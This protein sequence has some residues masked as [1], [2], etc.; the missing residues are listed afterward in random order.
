MSS[1]QV[2]I[3]RRTERVRS[4]GWCLSIAALAAAILAARG[5]QAEPSACVALRACEPGGSECD[6]ECPIIPH[7]GTARRDALVVLDTEARSAAAGG[8]Y[9]LAAARFVCLFR[10]DPQAETAGSLAV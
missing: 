9:T 4:P 3:V 10:A 6:E 7:A 8:D 5:A 2:P 1:N